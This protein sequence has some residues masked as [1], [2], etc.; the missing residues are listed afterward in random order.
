MPLFHIHGLVTALLATLRAGGSV[1]CTPGFHQVHFFDWLDELEPTWYTA[2]PS[3]HAGVLLR[4]RGRSESAS[5]HKLRFVRSSSAAL[6]AT[7][8]RELETVFDVPVIEAYGMTEA[9]HQMA[10]NPLPPA[11]RKPGTVGKAAGPEVAV[12]DPS[13]RKLSAGEIGEV[14]I[15]G[16]SVFA[17]YETSSDAEPFTEGGWFRTGDEGFLDEEGYLTLRGRIKEIINRGGEKISP[18]EVDDALLA[19]QGVAQAVTFAMSDPQL[20]EEVAAAVVLAR[21]AQLDERDLQ[22]FVAAQLAPFKVPRRILVVD[23][24]PTGATGKLQRIGLAERLGIENGAGPV[25]GRR[26]YRFL[27][28]QLIEIWESVLDMRGLDV[29]SDFFAL[30]GD[31]ILGAEAVARVRDLVGD[32]DLPLISIVRAP[33]PAAMASEVVSNVGLGSSG[34]VPL[35]PEGTRTPLFLVH[36]GDGEL[37]TYPA[38]TTR[39]GTDQPSYGLRAR[40]V[41]D[42]GETMPSS[43]PEI[44]ADYVSEVQRIQPHGPYVLGGFCVG[45]AIA[46]EMASQLQAAGEEIGLIVLL[47]PR[48]GRPRGLRAD[49]WRITRAVRERRLMHAVGRRFDRTKK[50]TLQTPDAA[51][52]LERL[53]ESSV[54]RPVRA[55]A[56]VF[57]SQEYPRFGIP[58]WYLTELVAPR[59]L[60]ELS[61]SHTRLLLPPNVDVVVQGIGDALSPTTAGNGAS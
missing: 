60:Q 25:A 3:M 11:V 55:P 44:A 20:G 52:K 15:R 26:P 58:R 9:A 22:D 32:P 45:G 43:V 33:T 40:G 37:L 27:E 4:A 16:E 57:L 35:Q 46:V 61:C 48:F 14:A 18:L 21:G 17:G 5:R 36:P 1:A 6:P 12:L 47:D 24:L 13:G 34:A 30:G 31:S 8:H 38:L 51:V 49:L 42:D 53:R 2:V 56:I 10:S 59:S 23:E 28:P 54:S 39:L 29:G 19:H 7:V 41:D 50:A